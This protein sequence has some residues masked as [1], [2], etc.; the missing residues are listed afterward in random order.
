MPRVSIV[1]PTYNQAG[2]LRECLDSVRAQ[3]VTDWEA[4]VVNNFSDDDTRD[5][6]LSLGDPRI[7]L[8][9]FANHGVIAASRNLG[10]GKSSAEWVAFLDSDDLWEPAKLEKSLAAGDGAD[11]VS[12]PEHLYR[13]GQKVGRTALGNPERA[14]FRALLLDGNI[15]SPSA[16][17]VRRPVLDRAGGFCVDTEVVTAEDHDLWLRLAKTGARMAFLSEALGYFRL[18]GAQNSRSVARHMAASLAVIDRHAGDLT[19]AAPLACRRARSRV[20]Y[21]AGR[22]LQKAGQNRE[23]LT[24]FLRAAREW[25]FSVKLAVAAGMAAALSQP[26]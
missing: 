14:S 8:V 2:F 3:T 26:R 20:I 7:T 23:A 24:L 22:T 12:H 19:P 9:D 21:A 13:D 25:P 16:V 11:L 1:I 18:H 15:L 5:V 4:I 17:L 6:A 10:I